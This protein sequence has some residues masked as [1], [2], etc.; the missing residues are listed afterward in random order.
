MAALVTGSMVK[1]TN[2]YNG[3]APGSVFIKVEQDEDDSSCVH[4][5]GP[6]DIEDQDDVEGVYCNRFE[7][8]T[9]NR[10]LVVRNVGPDTSRRLQLAAF[11]NGWQWGD[12]STQVINT[13][14]RTLTFYYSEKKNLPRR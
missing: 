12:G 4:V 7:R 14:S 8:Y 2:V 6:L 9:L 13:G 5:F 3:W 11:D 1:L 10:S